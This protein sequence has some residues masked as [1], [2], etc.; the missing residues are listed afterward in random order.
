[1]F[2][3]LFLCLSCCERFCKES[4][5]AESAVMLLPVSE[6]EML[7]TVQFLG[8]SHREMNFQN[9]AAIQTLGTSWKCHPRAQHTPDTP[10]VWKRLSFILPCWATRAAAISH[11]L[12]NVWIHWSGIHYTSVLPWRGVDL[13]LPLKRFTLGRAGWS[14]LFSLNTDT[15]DL[16]IGRYRS[17][18]CI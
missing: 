7:F 6:Q 17:D 11:F 3:E 5:Q 10:L 1:M 8:A 16:H 4:S 2:L 9:T 15:C 14:S 12:K 13:L 18:T